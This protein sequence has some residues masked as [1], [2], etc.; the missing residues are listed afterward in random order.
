MIPLAGPAN[1]EAG[2]CADILVGDEK[3]YKGTMGTSVAR[4]FDYTAALTGVNEKTLRS[5][6]KV[7]GTDYET[8]LINQ[9]SHAGYYPG[10][11]PDPEADIWNE[12]RD[13]RRADRGAGGA[14]K[15][16]D[17]IASVG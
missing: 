9:K 3:E 7:K 12:R 16:I 15:R 4:I 11:F 13:L 2:I 1:K 14:D 6:G 5:M 17:T 8:V 10:R